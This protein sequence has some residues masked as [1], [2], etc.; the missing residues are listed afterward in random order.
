M[1]AQYYKCKYAMYINYQTI[2]RVL[3]YSSQLIWWYLEK[4]GFSPQYV[5]QLK[6]LQSSLSLARKC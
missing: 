2:T 1:F 4:R 3:Q 5:E 6:Q